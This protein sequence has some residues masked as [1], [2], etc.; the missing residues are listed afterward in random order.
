MAGGKRATIEHSRWL[1]AAALGLLA[2]GLIS[3]II[4]VPDHFPANLIAVLLLGGAMLAALRGLLRSGPSRLTWL[5]VAALMAIGGIALRL[6]S[7]DLNDIPTIGCWL[8][9]VIAVRAAL[10]GRVRLPKAQRPAAAVMFW[11]P[12]SGDGKAV[13]AGLAAAAQQRGI[14]PIELKPG[15]DLNRL[16]ETAIA[17]GADALAAAG[18]DGTQGIVAAIAA[19]HD[20]PFACIPAGTRNHFALD[21]GVDRDDLIGALDAFVEGGEKRVDLAELNGQVFVNNVSLG[22]YAEAVQSDGYRDAKL[23]TL[24]ETAPE[25]AGPEGSGIGLRWSAPGAANADDAVALLVSNNRYIVGS[26]IG[27]GTRPAIDDGQL[28]ITVFTAGAASGG[29]PGT[30][31]LPWQQ[32]SAASF[33]VDGDGPVAAG[34]DGEA[35]RFEPPLR[36]R[37]RPGVLRVRIAAQHPGASP[38]AA[39]PER[40]VEIPCV[41]WRI[42]LGR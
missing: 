15:D 8:L 34:V 30:P 2:V 35:M 6:V 11:N 7:F 3:A 27:S 4:S 26:V 18:G 16:V 23:A 29:L 39:L 32:W 38:S 9:A 24:L 33:D 37:I 21:L 28:G 12:R 19:Q 42:A 10:H 36:F 14:R 25:V 20:L 5:S 31:Q 40:L 13:A 17:D 1:A 41:L 22:L